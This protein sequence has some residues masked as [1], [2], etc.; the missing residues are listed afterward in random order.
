MFMQAGFLLLEVGFS[1]MKNAG[2]VGRQGARELLD[3][4]PLSTG[5]S[6]SRF[7]LRRRAARSPARTA[8]SSH[9]P[10]RS[11]SRPCRLDAA[12]A[13]FFFQF[14][15][16]A[17]SLAIVWG[18]TLERIKF[19]A[20]LIYAVVFAAL[21]YPIIS[22]WIFGGGWLQENFGHRRTSPARRSST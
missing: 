13:K 21:I 11:T 15:F 20:Y 19:G 10:T 16:C 12:S 9:R 17:V 1:R 2:T 6:G 3:L 7:G 4:R 22:H 8:S 14:A 18:T 5:R